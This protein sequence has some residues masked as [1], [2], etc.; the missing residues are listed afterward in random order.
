M[1]R[2]GK[3]NMEEYIQACALAQIVA[4]DLLIK[5]NEGKYLLGMRRNPPAKNTYFVPGSRAF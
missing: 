2:N 3:L 5:N 1:N 4:L